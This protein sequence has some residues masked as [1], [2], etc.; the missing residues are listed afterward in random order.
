MTVFLAPQ[1][2]P[3]NTPEVSIC[4]ISPLNFNVTTEQ[5]KTNEFPQKY[6]AS[7]KQEKRLISHFF[8]FIG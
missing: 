1:I 2:L 8:I 5:R 6:I 7:D 3:L 4:K